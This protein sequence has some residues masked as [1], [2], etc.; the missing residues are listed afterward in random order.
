MNRNEIRM[1]TAADNKKIVSGKKIALNDVLRFLVTNTPEITVGVMGLVHAFLLIIFL[2]ADVTPL[3]VFNVVSVIIYVVCMIL[4]RLR[5]NMPVY[6]SI[7]LEVNTYTVVS[8]YYIGIRCGTY[9]FMF[10]IV[11]IMIYF[12]SKM[13]Q[14]KRRMS[15]VIMLLLNFAVFVVTY[16]VFFGIQ[17]VYDVSP[18]ITLILVIFSAFAMIFS[19]IFYNTIYIYSTENMVINLEE[20]NKQLSADAHEDALTSLLNRRGFLPL[21]KTL[22]EGDTYTRF[23]VAFCDLDDFKRVNDSYGHDAGDE[24]LKH[25]ATMIRQ[26]LPGCDVCRWGGEEFVI[27]LKDT[28]LVS[29]KGRVERLRK[30]VESNPTS[31]FGKQIFVTL[32]IG[33]EEYRENYTEPEA[34]IRKADERMYYGKQHGKNIVVF[35]DNG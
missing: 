10:S 21:V 4:C 30:T 2:I 11:P 18:V 20:K 9:F 13:F 34:V 14:G 27:L 32:T 8:T 12:G 31:F 1:S 35:E 16:V 22:M 6:A 33:L 5:Y 24:V 15:L 23:C 26:E 7:I 17:P 3:A 19:V 29:A 25:A 28:D